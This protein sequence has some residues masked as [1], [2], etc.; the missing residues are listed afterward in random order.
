MRSTEVVYCIE[1]SLAV[2]WPRMWYGDATVRR[3]VTVQIYSYMQTYTHTTQYT[4]FADPAPYI[5]GIESASSWSETDFLNQETS[6]LAFFLAL[7]RSV[8]RL[9]YSSGRI[10]RVPSVTEHSG[11]NEFN[12]RRESVYSNNSLY[13]THVVMIT[14]ATRLNIGVSIN[15]E[16]ILQ[17]TLY[18]ASRLS[19]FVVA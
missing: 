1:K 10:R 17:Y 11:L 19:G 18:N 5:N 13:S 6:Q 16:T 8:A 14:C 15:I 7:W 2:R 3:R 9:R 12:G 4:K